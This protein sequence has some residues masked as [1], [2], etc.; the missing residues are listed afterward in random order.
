MLNRSTEDYIK[1]I[2]K[3]GR[4]GG[5]V[6]TSALA[7]SLQLSDPSITDMIKKLSE[8]GLVRY[9]PYKGT[10][11]T[12]RG[13]AMAVKILRR[14]RLWEMFLARYLGYTWDEIHDEADRL[15]H[16]TSDVLEQKLDHLLGFPRVDPHGD[17]IPSADGRL[18]HA[19]LTALTACAEGEVV[20][21]QRVS[22]AEPRILRHATRLGVGLDTRLRVRE[23]LPFDGSMTLE[24]GGR[25]LFISREVADAIFVCKAE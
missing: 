8:R 17:P 22:D 11:L 4:Q 19:P 25:E 13:A 18:E 20:R 14:H 10:E 3:L 1:H 23:K 5:K 12:A 24:L 6:T 7:G 15:E 2:Y 9:T 21:V 16:V